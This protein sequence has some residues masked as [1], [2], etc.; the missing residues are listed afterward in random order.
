MSGQHQFIGGSYWGASRSNS[1]GGSHAEQA[2]AFDSTVPDNHS[3]RSND[4]RRIRGKA[5]RCAQLRRFPDL[6]Q[7]VRVRE[8]WGRLRIA[9]FSRLP[10]R[11]KRLHDV[12]LWG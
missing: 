11:S 5:S 4:D 2:R 6:W 7:R 1:M 3:V 9:H 12:R 8:F 10:G